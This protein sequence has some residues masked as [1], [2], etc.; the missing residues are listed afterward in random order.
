MKDSSNAAISA[1]TE[2]RTGHSEPHDR[3]L[4][5]EE[6]LR[7]AL[8]AAEIGLW[9]VDV[10]AGKL[11][12][13][14]RCKAMF[15][16]APDVQ[17]TMD[18]FYAGLH[19][20][21][22]AATIAAYLAAQ[23][24][25]QRS[26]YDVEYRTVGADGVV[27]WAAAKG[28]AIFED[29]GRCIRVV[30]NIIDITARKQAERRQAVM[31]ELTDLLRIGDTDQAL[32]AACALMGRYFGVSRVGY[33]LL[34]P[35]EDIFSYTV[36]WTDGFVPPLL[37]DYPAHVFGEKIVAALSAGQTIV[38]D[39]LFAASI[40]D[41]ARTLE[42]AADV[43]TRAILVVP[44]LRGGRLRTIVYLN[45]Q[46][47]RH[48]DPAEIA[49]ME[50]VAERT[51]Q[52]IDRAENIRELT[53][54]RRKAEEASLA[55]TEF[56]ANMS[57]EIRTPMNAIIGIGTLLAM[58]QPLTARQQEFVKT[59][60]VSA[61]GLLELIND[62]LDV[63]KIEAH[64]VEL[65]EV[66]FS[67]EQILLEV[68]SMMTVRS[69]EKGLTFTTAIDSIRGRTFAGDPMR[70]RQIVLNLCSNAVKFTQ[71]GGVEI[72]VA[73]GAEDSVAISVRDTGIGIAPENLSTIFDKFV[74][75]DNSI[76]RKYGGTGLG[77]AITRNLAELM[78]GAIAID[79]QP[80]HGSTFTV[81]LPL[82]LTDAPQAADPIAAPPP[83][84]GAARI[85]LVEDH[86]PNVLV[87]TTFLEAF[88]YQIEVAGH[89]E[90]AVNALK[91]APFDLVLM[92][93][94][95]PGMNGFEATRLIREHEQN[96]GQPPVVI[97]G[98][99]AH[100]LAGDRDRCLAAGMDDYIAKPFDPEALRL[101]LQTALDSR[102]A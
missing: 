50:A 8:D 41:E 19:P 17:V 79:S 97:I 21:D 46:Q 48:W 23:D 78:G 60:N 88:G 90:M 92:D 59:L 53:Q 87:A 76:S 40:S 15:G 91:A 57:H 42:T 25:A 7:L 94:Q 22:R 89:G 84:S 81:T 62:L 82:R 14:A 54:A 31:L 61:K 16:V 34:D 51:R 95:M 37:G 75:A 32:H 26:F 101:K 74:Q 3:T 44:F 47:P 39:D 5:T 73:C 49:F 6:Q 102:T 33:G 65:E 100:A 38:V 43:D 10:A 85:L 55:K 72:R 45:A 98:M 66:P 80:G 96:T 99:T 52:L 12:W 70:L 9:D 27:R 64:T 68:A 67:L 36:C 63:A 18:D 2:P 77:L 20:D 13:D 83:Q 86:E 11:F 35:V 71:T 69:R 4:I 56:L 28:R 24:P 30:G 29:D 58:S 1:K 93:V